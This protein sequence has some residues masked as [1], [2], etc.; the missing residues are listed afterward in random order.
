MVENKDCWLKERCNHR[1]C[2]G[3]CMRLFKLDKLFDNALIAYNQRKNIQLRVDSDKVDF[4]E[5]TKLSHISN[6]TL[7]FVANGDNLF[8]HST[9]C[10]NGKT[11]WALRIVSNYL[12][13]VWITSDI[14]DCKVLFINVPRFLLELKSNIEN[15]SDYI[16]H[17]KEN[18][19]NADIVV[20][21]DIGT[22]SITTFETENL[23]SIIDNRINLGKSNIY[24]SNLK[25]DDLYEFLGNRLASRLLG[26]KYNIELHG[27]D[28]RGLCLTD[29]L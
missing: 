28:K 6:N 20:W 22:K 24:T 11:S 19:L 15:K 26:S 16:S 2:N 5:F 1:D 8:I 27:K 13:K 25:D 10:G 7:D 21:D 23:L 3:F 9:T 18:V 4:D 12:D 29:N 14:D 17:I